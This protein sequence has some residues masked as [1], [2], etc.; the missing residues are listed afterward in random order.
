MGL[1]LFAAPVLVAAA[2][3]GCGPAG[4]EGLAAGGR[5]CVSL[6]RQLDI[7]ERWQTTPFD[8]SATAIPSQIEPVAI[9]LRS[10]DCLTSIDRPGMAAAL[11]DPSLPRGTGSWDPNGALVA[12]GAVTS[13]RA[14]FH[15]LD[16]FESLGYH[17]Y[18][19]GT[20]GVGRRIYVGP[21]A[22]EAGVAA[23]MEAAQRAG[24]DYPYVKRAG[25]SFFGGVVQSR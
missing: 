20:A 14:D 8:D 16:Y 9:W 18:S 15:A 4:M 11:A 6:F 13:T 3:A 25:R 23:V 21:M 1:R 10:H 17:A 12:V 7:V 22:T 2:L 24:F 5:S 19:I